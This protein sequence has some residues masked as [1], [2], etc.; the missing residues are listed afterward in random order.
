[1]STGL[2]TIRA[3][4]KPGVCLF[5]PREVT[6]GRVLCGHQRCTR[7][8]ARAWHQDA[9]TRHPE[10]YGSEFYK[11]KGTRS[12]RQ[13]R[14]ARARP[15]QLPVVE[16]YAVP[17]AAEMPPEPHR[18]VTF[19]IGSVYVPRPVRQVAP[20]A[21]PAPADLEPMG[22]GPE[23]PPELRHDRREP[24]GEAAVRLA[25]RRG[26]VDAETLQT[27]LGLT[28]GAANQLLRRLALVGLL[29]RAAAGRYVPSES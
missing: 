13:A 11:A 7:A 9:R 23:L 3:D 5:C 6:Q 24:K 26:E 2:A 29:K 25:R 14:R 20:V 19:P 17:P 21:A 4:A 27:E 15:E 22:L 12:P 18:R 1:M 16:V 28:Q 8:Y 10:R